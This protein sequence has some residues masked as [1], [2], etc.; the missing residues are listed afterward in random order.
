[1]PY[2]GLPDSPQRSAAILTSLRV[3]SAEVSP[4][5]PEA[6]FRLAQYQGCLRYLGYRGGL[7]DDAAVTAWQQAVIQKHGYT[8]RDL[9]ESFSD[10]IERRRLAMDGEEPRA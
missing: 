1:L 5:E 2:S 6:E 3:I 8:P 9:G 7:D 4:D 10:W